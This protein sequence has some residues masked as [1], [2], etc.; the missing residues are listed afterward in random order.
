MAGEGQRFGSPIPK[1]FH[2]LNDKRIYSYAL[3][4]LLDLDIFDE[5]LLACSSQWI[6]EIQ[7]EIG[8]FPRLVEG[9]LSRQE[10]SYKGLSS[11]SFS[12]DI[13]LIH[14]AVRPFVTLEILQKNIEQAIVFGAVDTCIPCTDTL[15]FSKNQQIIETIPA[16]ENYWRGQ[17]P[18]TF[19]YTKILNAHQQALKRGIR[20]A[21]DDCQLV[22]LLGG[23]VK[24][25]L[26]D[27]KNFKITS[28]FDLTLAKTLL[29]SEIYQ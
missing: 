16:R 29:D 3:E 13:V 10:S 5:I 11:F 2:L 18:Q 15:V 24:I 22:L 4:T 28:S 14:D 7:Q 9:G 20:N 8:S 19:Q 26:G 12:P 17:T 21:T 6:K 27:E 25:V 1:Q 23:E